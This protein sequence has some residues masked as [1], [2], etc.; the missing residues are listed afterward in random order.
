MKV[1]SK[2]SLLC[3]LTFSVVFLITSVIIYLLYYGYT[4]KYIDTGL[5]KTATITALF[6]LEEDELNKEEY[7]L[8]RKEFDEFVT[9]SLYQIYNEQDSVSYGSKSI[10]TAPHILDEVRQKEQLAFTENDYFCYAIFYEDNQGDFVVIAREKKEVL[11]EQLNGLLS[12]LVSAF[13][14]GIVATIFLSMWLARVAYRPFRKI[15]DQVNNISTNKLDVQIAYPETKDELQDLISTFNN[16]LTKIS[17]TVVI[18]KNFIN[19]VSHEF[20]TPL[21]AILGNLEV[22]SIKDRSPQ[23]YEQLTQ[24]LIV[25]I[26]QLEEMLDT[27]MIVSDLREDVATSVRTRI[28]ELIW[29]IISKLTD[30]YTD[31]KILVNIA[32]EPQ[33]ENLLFVDTDR[34]Q[35]LMALFNLIE[36]AVKYGNK[37]SVEILI[38]TNQ[39][40]LS[41]A[42]KDQGIGIPK[43]KLEH[44][45]KP[46]LRGGNTSLVEGSGIG[47]SIALRILEKNKIKYT[48]VSEIN[49]GTVI[50]ILF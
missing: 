47:L 31:A 29:Q 18:Q 35:L 36:N 7:A 24:K 3:T 44:I 15:I 22:F 25:E 17:E 6:Y 10:K 5:V 1:Q 46:F 34:T 28:D 40:S 41:V 38:S 23:E 48:I 45:S 14:L 42:I 37:K 16:L 50:T 12:I 27:L 2:L 39:K 21:A 13:L 30:R 11:F 26:N 49:R 9:N 43:E 20:K 4:K 8:V 19:Y 32:V 33:D